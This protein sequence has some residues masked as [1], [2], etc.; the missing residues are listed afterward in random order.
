MKKK[1]FVRETLNYSFIVMEA[2]TIKEVTPWA[3]KID[4]YQGINVKEV[5]FNSE[6]EQGM[7]ISSTYSRFNI[8]AMLDELGLERVVKPS[9]KILWT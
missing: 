4:D 1:V 8:N 5:K 6:L 9:R 2:K 7:I 3:D